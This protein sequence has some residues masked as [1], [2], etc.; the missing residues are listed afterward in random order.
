MYNWLQY[1][2]HG[3][4]ALAF[5]LTAVATFNQKTPK[6][7]LQKSRLLLILFLSA[8]GFFHGMTAAGRMSASWVDAGLL[9][10]VLVPVSLGILREQ[11]GT[12]RNSDLSADGHVRDLE[13][14]NARESLELVHTAACLATWIW[15]LKA[16]T[17]EWGA[18]STRL[19]G[20]PENVQK[21]DFAAITDMTHPD[22][23]KKALES[24]RHAIEDSGFLDH[25]FR[26]IRPDGDVR[27]LLGR[28]KVFYDANGQA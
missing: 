9:A 12:H 11:S 14:E 18:G 17:V 24:S 19:F 1:V 25:T 16:N 23:R 7:D 28:G 27:W 21:T 3:L 4:I 22:D 13:L 26:A 5:F 15:D 10:L 6:L 2:S 20:L 8:C